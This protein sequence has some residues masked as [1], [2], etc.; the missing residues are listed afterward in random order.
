M[1]TSLVWD[2]LRCNVDVALRLGLNASASGFETETG[3]SSDSG[4]SS[5]TENATDPFAAL[6]AS[7]LHTAVVAAR[8][9]TITTIFTTVVWAALLLG[10]WVYRREVV[11]R[12]RA[13]LLL[14]LQAVGGCIWAWAQT[15]A[16]LGVWGPRSPSA[17][18]ADLVVT[19]LFGY[20]VWITALA[21]WL[22]GY[23]NTRVSPLEAGLGS[24][25]TSPTAPAFEL[26]QSASTSPSLHSPPSSSRSTEHPLGGKSF[27]RRATEHGQKPGPRVGARSCRVWWVRLLVANPGLWVCTW[28]V[29]VA[30]NGVTTTGCAT[31]PCVLTPSARYH[32][33]G[34]TGI[35][36][37]VLGALLVAA[38]TPTF[39]LAT[40]RGV[41]GGL[42]LG[43]ILG[44]AAMVPASALTPGVTTAAL[45]IVC[46]N[47]L[48][49]WLAVATAGEVVVLC[50][51]NRAGAAAAVPLVVLEL[52]AAAGWVQVFDP[53]EP[54]GGRWGLLAPAGT[55]L[56]TPPGTRGFPNTPAHLGAPRGLQLTWKHG[57]RRGASGVSTSNAPEVS[58]VDVVMQVSASTQQRNGA[59]QHPGVGSGG[60]GSSSS[61][62]ESSPILK[63]VAAWNPIA[64]LSGADS[65]F[66]R[67]SARAISALD[68]NSNSS[69]SSS[70]KP[71]TTTGTGTGA[72]AGTVAGSRDA[73]T[74]ISLQSSSVN[75]GLTRVKFGAFTDTAP[76]G[77]AVPEPALDTLFEVGSDSDDSD[78]FSGSSKEA[79]GA[80]AA[81]AFASASASTSGLRGVALT[82]A[83]TPTLETGPE[84][85]AVSTSTPA[86]MAMPVPARLP[87]PVLDINPDLDITPGHNQHQTQTQTQFMHPNPATTVAL[88]RGL[89]SFPA[90]A[91]TVG[92]QTGMVLLLALPTTA[93]WALRVASEMHLTPQVLVSCRACILFLHEVATLRTAFSQVSSPGDVAAAAVRVDAIVQAYLVPRLGTRA[94][95]TTALATSD[96]SAWDA[97]LTWLGRAF[98]R[99]RPFVPPPPGV[100]GVW[101]AAGPAAVTA[102][103]TSLGTGGMGVEVGVVPMNTPEGA[104]PAALEAAITAA[105]AALF[106]NNRAFCEGN[107]TATPPWDPSVFDDIAGI[108]ASYLHTVLWKPLESAGAFNTLINALGTLLWHV[109][110]RLLPRPNQALR[111]ASRS[112]TETE[113]GT[114]TRTKTKTR[115]RMGSPR[116]VDRGPEPLLSNHRDGITQ[117][118]IKI[119][120][121]DMLSALVSAA[122]RAEAG[123]EAGAGAGTRARARARA[124]TRSGAGVGAG[125]VAAH[126]FINEDDDDED[127]NEEVTINMDPIHKPLGLSEGHRQGSGTHSDVREPPQVPCADQKQS[128]L[129]V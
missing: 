82:R 31:A 3:S 64:A 115:T 56:I 50:A 41:A 88:G 69:S 38:A 46:T 87:G 71:G 42:A 101:R 36:C 96:L 33:L 51:T 52:G 48:V 28:V 13:P 19:Y 18:A 1:N 21:A 5:E 114:R 111:W 27:I 59:A 35:G 58:R 47:V 11:V 103:M 2:T 100:P 91:A 79:K 102:W 119:R 105:T 30:V 77:V 127:G 45:Y 75:S 32:L 66:T 44:Y 25:L 110:D 93:A 16:L 78:G 112:E 17:C 98:G 43:L 53:V 83:S 116:S 65:R 89:E 20:G 54:Y 22:A 125:G 29:H 37:L 92:T 80:P 10:L 24:D 39:A 7:A 26:P 126:V 109:M 95:T 81:S 123:A 70:S 84:S 124:N 99:R 104:A 60:S 15:G 94:D 55:T 73:S 120:T 57:Q 72:G 6:I 97:P 117:G 122:A 12:L 40:N 86:P 8:L 14:T 106:A 113:T 9:A 23:I 107:D 4:S 129:L 85:V 90:L 68:S 61:V 67:Q 62:I 118:G 121:A 34:V 108:V 49:V 63:W 74:G 76:G 128:P